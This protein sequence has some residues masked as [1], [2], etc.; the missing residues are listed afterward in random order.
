MEY[1]DKCLKDFKFHKKVERETIE[2]Y[3]KILP[4]EI[5]Y[6]WENYGYGTFYNGYF[7]VVDPDEYDPILKDSVEEYDGG[8]TLFTT[9]LGDLIVSEYREK[10]NEYRLVMVGYRKAE[11]DFVLRLDIIFKHF[12]DDRGIFEEVL[13]T[14]PYEKMLDT[15]GDVDYGECYGFSQI[16]SI[17]KYRKIKDMEKLDVKKYI[18]TMIS[19]LGKIYY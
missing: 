7:Q 1:V 9:G 13:L 3:R 18:Y 19:L 15:L 14:L 10:T 17:S 5:I 4:K 6:I 2:K 12:F 8:V 16:K 11:L